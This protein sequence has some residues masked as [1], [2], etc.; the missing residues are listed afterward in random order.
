MSWRARQ[1]RRPHRTGGSAW[2]RMQETPLELAIAGLAFAA[3]ILGLVT[4]WATLPFLYAALYVGLGVGGLVIMVG[5]LRDSL[6]VESAGLALLI[7]AFAF[8]ALRELSHAQDAEQIGSVLLNTGALA[9]GFGVRLWVVRR[10]ARTRETAA[11]K[12]RE[13]RRG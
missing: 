8:I 10:A 5:R 13:R 11:R 7:G 6:H 2:L 4:E 9:L 3:A 1:R 12:V